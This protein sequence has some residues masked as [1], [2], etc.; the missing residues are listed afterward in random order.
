MLDR[1]SLISAGGL[2]LVGTAAASVLVAGGTPEARAL[3]ASLGH[4]DHH[5]HGA[6]HGSGG[7][8]G[9]MPRPHRPA[10]AGTHPAYEKFSLPM[11]LLEDAVPTRSNPAGDVYESEIRELTAEIYPGRPTSVYGYFGSWVPPVIRAEK[12]RRVTVVQ[13]NRTTT[14]ISVHLHGGV[15]EAKSDGQMSLAVQPG[16]SRR[17]RYDNTQNAAALWLHDHTHHTEAEQVYRGMASPY[18]ISSPEERRL[19]LPSGEF[20]VPILLR[21]ADVDERGDL[22]F[23]MDDTANRTTIMANGVPWPHMDVKRRKYRFRLINSSNM[24]FFV[25]GLSDGTPLTVIGTDDGL[26]AGPAVAPVVVLSPGERTD[27]VVD[28]TRWE[29]G[30][31]VTMMNY[32]GPGDM[33]DVGQ[34][35]QFRIGEDVPDDSVVPEVLTALPAPGPAAMQRTFTIAS[36][37]PDEP[38]MWGHINGRTFDMDRI[39]FRVRRGVTEEWLITNANATVPHNFHVHLAHM[40][41]ID[42][43]GAEPAPAERGDKD[44]VTVYPGETVRVRLTF[45]RHRGVYPYHCHMIDHGA[46]GMMG[47][48]EVV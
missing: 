46:M 13:R 8:A 23:T 3:N 4:D 41:I 42:R 15:T 24:R 27:L 43:S 19:G 25:L 48:L 2:C 17:Y 1:R 40:R 37:E 47:Q 31:T 11:P 33:A 28:F 39:D 34:V 14:P 32:S 44:T 12:G 22:V 9:S 38:M 29:A 20:E 21:D 7:H 35:L 10:D 30:Q 6:G 18:I 16:K 5:G 45:T 36:S 26:L